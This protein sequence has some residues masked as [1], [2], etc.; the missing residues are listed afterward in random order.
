M[1]AM[2]DRLLVIEE[3]FPMKCTTAEFEEFMRKAAPRVDGWI[4]HYF[5][6]TPDEHR[7]GAEPAG[8]AIAEF[9][10]YWKRGNTFN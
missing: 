7:N 10:E 2:S 6:H 5:G 1:F 8:E 3:C 4:S 9:F